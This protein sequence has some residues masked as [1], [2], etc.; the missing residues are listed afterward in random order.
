MTDWERFGAWVLVLTP[1]VG[2][3]LTAITFYLRALRAQGI[4]QF[5]ELNQRV[6]RL[7]ALIDSTMRRIAEIERSYTTKEEW[8]RESTLAR[9]ERRWLTEAVIRLETESQAAVGAAELTACVDR[10]TRAA[11]EAAD[12]LDRVSERLIE[13]AGEPSGQPGKQ[14]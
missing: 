3:P 13:A 10:T 12:K 11:L 7:D 2:V 5:A 8:V 6:V 14:N 9:G 4:S 1:L